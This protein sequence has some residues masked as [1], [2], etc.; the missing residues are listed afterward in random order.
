MGTPT[1]SGELSGAGC[2]GIRPMRMVGNEDLKLVVGRFAFS[3][4]YATGGE[5]PTAADFGLNEIVTMVFTPSVSGQT[6]IK[7]A[8][9]LPPAFDP[10]TGKVTAIGASA[11]PAGMNLVEEVS[12]YTDLSA[13]VF[14]CIVVGR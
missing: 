7:G 13:Q 5:T 4:S 11:V 6:A 2:G 3:S 10:E 8:A 14:M 9:M 1:C 12:A